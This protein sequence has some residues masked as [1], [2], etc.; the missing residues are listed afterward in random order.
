MLL[1]SAGDEGGI[2][3]EAEEEWEERFAEGCAV[4][5][6]IG[7]VEPLQELVPSEVGHIG[8]TSERGEERL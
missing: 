4:V 3:K 2:C 1:F 7:I 8:D 6:L 5:R